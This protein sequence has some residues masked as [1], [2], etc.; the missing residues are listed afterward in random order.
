M[1]RTFLGMR[2]NG[3]FEMNQAGKQNT[4][5]RFNDD[6]TSNIEFHQ[7]LKNDGRPNHTD[8][9]MWARPLAGNENMDLRGSNATGLT[10]MNQYIL[11]N[12]LLS[13]N[14]NI[15]QAF[16]PGA[17]EFLGGLTPSDFFSLFPG[18][19]YNPLGIS[20]ANFLN[21]LNMKDMMGPLFS[22]M[23]LGGVGA[24]RGANP[25]G[26]FQ[27]NQSLTNQL[28]SAPNNMP[29][30]SSQ[31]EHFFNWRAPFR[32]AAT[33]V[34]IAYLIYHKK[35]QYAENL[36]DEERTKRD[37]TFNARRLKE[38]KVNEQKQSG[39]PQSELNDIVVG[40]ESKKNQRNEPI[41]VEDGS[42]D[43]Q[44]F[45]E[46]P[47]I[48]EEHRELRK[49]E[50]EKRVPEKEKLE[51]K[52]E[53]KVEE[54]KEEKIEE[55]QIPVGHEVIEIEE[56]TPPLAPADLQKRQVSFQIPQPQALSLD[57]IQNHMP[58]HPEMIYAMRHDDPRREAD[59]RLHMIPEGFGDDKDNDP[60]RQGRKLY[61]IET[62]NNAN[63]FV[64]R[65][66]PEGAGNTQASGEARE[67]RHSPEPDV[68]LGR[69]NRSI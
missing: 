64:I 18:A 16:Q 43:E 47:K 23:G 69:D 12:H 44:P 52:V 28:A 42:D 24:G 38:R 40:I 6:L 8:P 14:R 4:L 61:R 39:L 46:E 26:M 29:Y 56:N 17:E 37:P 10:E 62:G 5:Y 21:T 49:M 20:G 59:E 36:T 45:E 66:F 22:Q 68:S 32:R 30:R 33:H 15:F 50:D 58:L 57:A 54:K 31:G 51:E 7:L 11:A 34:A 63:Q 27:M 35:C 67:G 25:P 48:E 53:D 13:N 19:V 65:K 41:E 9:N 2:D 3:M 55:S 1:N 60:F